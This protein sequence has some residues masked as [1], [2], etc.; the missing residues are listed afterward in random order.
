MVELA[1]TG[2]TTLAYVFYGRDAG[3]G[4]GYFTDLSRSKIIDDMKP[5]T[6]CS[7]A[8]FYCNYKE[9]QQ[10]DPASI[11]RSLVK[12]LC[13]MSRSGF[14]EPVLSI[15]RKRK[16]EADLTNLLSVSEC[17]DLLITL[18]TG[19]LRTTIVIDALDECDP[20]TRGS[21]CDVLEQTVSSSKT[22]IQGTI[23][24]FITSRNDGDLRRRFEGSPNVYIQ[25]RDSSKD[26]NLYIE[27]EIEA[28][29]RRKEL[30]GGA[31]ETTN[32]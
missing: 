22:P 29:I 20:D 10:S 16:S 7:L 13:L 21:L 3:E 9:D 4:A 15:Y 25:E 23:K 12:Q 8:Y 31:A 27:A 28:C 2:K 26:I 30:L 14:P 32:C 24:V 6:Q 18:S 17:K 5:E 19:F 11:L 1:G